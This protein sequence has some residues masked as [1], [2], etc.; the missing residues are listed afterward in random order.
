MSAGEQ[1]NL[2]FVAAGVPLVTSVENVERVVE[3]ELVTLLPFASHG[4]AGLLDV[5]GVPVPLF[6][7]E[8]FSQEQKALRRQGSF[9]LAAVMQT[10][11][12]RMA[13]RLDRLIGL[14]DPGEAL[15][16]VEGAVAE[17]PPRLQGCIGGA[18]L[19]DGLMAFYFTPDLFAD[20]LLDRE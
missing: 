10:Y 19:T 12:G 3:E 16:G 7:L 14:S 2:S 5:E 1:K 18:S 15:H 17:L 6:D 13:L 20:L 9:I 11:R 4:C 8:A